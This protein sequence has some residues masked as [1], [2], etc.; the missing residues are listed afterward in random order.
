MDKEN[1][2]ENGSEDLQESL[3][4]AHVRQ[5]AETYLSSMNPGT[6]WKWP[7]RSMIGFLRS[8][9]QIGRLCH[10]GDSAATNLVG[11]QVGR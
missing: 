2:V 9:L 10:T 3:K 7:L 8:I 6:S 11:L 5:T 4:M 1:G